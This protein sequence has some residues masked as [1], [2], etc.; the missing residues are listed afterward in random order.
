MKKR[1]LALTLAGGLM[2]GTLT[3]CSSA[4]KDSDVALTVEKEE[5]TAGVA[6]FYAR[7]TQAQYEKARLMRSQLRIP[8]RKIWKI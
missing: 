6:N 8:F 3:G 5:V 7:Y 1:F 2:I 4:I